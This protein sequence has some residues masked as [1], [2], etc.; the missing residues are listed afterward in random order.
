M[1]PFQITTLEA[2][3]KDFRAYYIMQNGT[4][5]YES[6]YN[7][8]ASSDKFSRLFGESLRMQ[9]APTVKDFIY[10]IALMPYFLFAKGETRALGVLI[11]IRLWDERV[12]K[13]YGMITET[14]LDRKV[15]S[16]FDQLSV[17]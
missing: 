16:V 9:V 5:K 2:T 7:K 14:E 8:V 4:E 12:N 1:L 17:Y 13:V 11:A 10:T 15:Q 3:F 6:L